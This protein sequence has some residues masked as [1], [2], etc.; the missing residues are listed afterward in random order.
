MHR[1]HNLLH[2]M[3]LVLLATVFMGCQK[4]ESI[5][6]SKDSIWSPK[7][8][9]VQ[10]IK[11]TA[12]C[13]WSINIDDDADWY[14]IDPMSGKG[15]KTV[16]IYVRPFVSS[17]EADYRKSSFT[18]TS[19]KGEVQL[20]VSVAQST[21]EPIALE[22]I[23]NTVFGAS[24]V[25]HWNTDFFGEIIEESYKHYE[26]NPFDTTAGY[27]MYFMKDGQGI[28][29]DNGGDTAVFYRFTY[30][31]NPYI[32]IF[33]LEFETV[34]D[35]LEV[36][37]ASVLDADENSFSFQHEYKPS[38]WERSSMTKI[39]IIPDDKGML[40]TKKATKKRKPDTPLFP[41]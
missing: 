21:L 16:S 2:S 4:Q 35:S 20:Q 23:T 39:G 34:T 31:Y 27:V 41:F 19:E 5:R 15:K 9:S 24:D 37:N 3:L 7:E 26:F 6:V 38:F 29:K 36:Y 1:K 40:L 12:N 18:I 13:K 25:A 17:N 30:D 14:S 22:S 28:Q 10:S 32:R 8:A 33:H 11:L